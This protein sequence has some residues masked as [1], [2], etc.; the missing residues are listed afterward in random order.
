MS[1]LLFANAFLSARELAHDAEVSLRMWHIMGTREDDLRLGALV[2][3]VLLLLLLL[4]N[5]LMPFGPF[6]VRS[7]KSIRSHIR[8]DPN[9]I[10][11]TTTTKPPTQTHNSKGK[12]PIQ[13]QAPRKT[14]RKGRNRSQTP[15]PRDGSRARRQRIR[16]KK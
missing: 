16:S 12:V 6:A 4:C 3:G 7:L 1:T 14:S 15:A 10:T 8:L 11:T 13:T 9:T 5:S 2:S